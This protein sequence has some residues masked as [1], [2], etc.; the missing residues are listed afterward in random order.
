MASFKT[1][2]AVCQRA[3]ELAQCDEVTFFPTARQYYNFSLDQ[4]S[5][6]YD[7]PYFRLEAAQVP[8][9][10]G[11]R[12]YALP[13]DYK[14]S[15]TVY[16]VNA[17]GIRREILVK[18]KYEFDTYVKQASASGEPQVAYIDIGAQEIVFDNSPSNTGYTYLLTYFRNP[19]EIDENGGDDSDTVDFELPL[20]LVYEIAAM[21]L[22]FDDDQ[23]AD[24]WHARATKLLNDGKINSYDNDSDSRVELAHSKFRPG[25]R[26][27]RG[28]AG[29][30]G[31]F[32]D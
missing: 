25:R 19:V 20:Y 14:R 2:G 27:G 21:L 29:W 28:G 5:R 24:G 9:V 26:P 3:M 8:F 6:A 22:D 18:S 23:R 30:A 12:A 10:P 31:F 32:G 17:S 4:A 13:A 11:T 15:D 7:W 16:F 1:I